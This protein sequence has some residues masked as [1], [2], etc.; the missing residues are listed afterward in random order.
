MVV[1]KA[2]HMSGS[3]AHITSSEVGS[4]IAKAIH[5]KNLKLIPKEVRA[6]AKIH[7]GSLSIEELK[8]DISIKAS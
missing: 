2:L 1:L 5:E 4:A 6:F 8:R 3:K 7:G